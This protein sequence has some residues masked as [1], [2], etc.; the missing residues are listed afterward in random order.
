MIVGFKDLKRRG[1]KSAEGLSLR[2]PR[3]CV[4]IPLAFEVL[5]KHQP[6]H[7]GVALSVHF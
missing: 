3:L 2:P 7:G 5:K 6:D 4:L 1:A